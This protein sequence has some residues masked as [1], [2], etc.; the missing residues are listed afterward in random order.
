MLRPFVARPV[1]RRNPGR[2]LQP[3]VSNVTTLKRA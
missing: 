2:R 3:H 1:R